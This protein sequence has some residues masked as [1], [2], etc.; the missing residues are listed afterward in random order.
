MRRVRRGDPRFKEHLSHGRA[1]QEVESGGLGTSGSNCTSNDLIKIYEAAKTR[2]P[3]ILLPAAG[4]T[5]LA[6]VVAVW[7][8]MSKPVRKVVISLAELGRAV[9]P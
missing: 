3:T 5:D 4:A 9:L 6:R 2:F 7:H 1:D 8:E